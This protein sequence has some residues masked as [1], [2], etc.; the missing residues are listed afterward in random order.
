MLWDRLH[1]ETWI[2]EGERLIFRSQLVADAERRLLETEAVADRPEI[3]LR[4]LPHGQ[5]TALAEVAFP[6][7]MSVAEAK[8]YLFHEL[9]EVP[10]QLRLRTASWTHSAETLELCLNSR[11]E[12]PLSRSVDLGDGVELQMHDLDGGPGQDE[13]TLQFQIAHGWDRA[14]AEAWVTRQLVKHDLG[15]TCRMERNYRQTP[16]LAAWL[17]AAVHPNR[18]HPTERSVDGAVQFEAV[19]RRAPSGPR[20]GGAGYEI[21]LADPGQ[22]ELLPNELAAMLPM[23]GYANLPEAQAIAEMMQRLPRDHTVALSAPYDSQ[24]AVLRHY[25]PN[26]ERVVSVADLAHQEC[27]LIVISLTRSH[28]SRAVTFGDDPSAII[29]LFTRP[30]CRI[31]VVGD[32]GTLNRR[33]GWEGAVDHLHEIAGEQERRWVNAL[34]P[35]LKPTGSQNVRTARGVRV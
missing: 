16:A 30:R 29:S 28:L 24:L 7:K 31:I 14:K 10:C 12:K 33:A 2:Y 17:D 6:A 22:R 4:I 15:R 23:R 13:F 11:N 34:L 21:D 18:R 8:E 5:E 20:R 27:D 19:P 1:R 26:D 3:E 35:F 25:L 9:G 32:P